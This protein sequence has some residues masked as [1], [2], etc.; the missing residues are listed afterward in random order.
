MELSAVVQSQSF[1]ICLMLSYC[2]GGGSDH[3]RGRS[4][5]KFLDDRKTRGSLNQSENA[6]VAI[7]AYDG[8]SFPV[9]QLLAGFH[10]SGSF[11]NMALSGQNTAWIPGIV[12]FPTSLGHDSQFFELIPALLSIEADSLVNGFVADS[13]LPMKPKVVG[14]LF[15]TPLL[16]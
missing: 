7:S 16:G 11:W 10:G 9:P 6:V 1:E 4:R 12:V 3:L 14:Y 5:F 13:E 8:I 2:V 15:G